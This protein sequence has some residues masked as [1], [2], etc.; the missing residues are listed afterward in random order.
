MGEQIEYDPPV[1]RKFHR[2]CSR[3]GEIR[4]HD[5]GATDGAQPAS[6]FPVQWGAALDA[7]TSASRRLKQGATATTATRQTQP[8]SASAA[9]GR[10]AGSSARREG[11]PGSPGVTL[12][13]ASPMPRRDVAGHH[14]R[15]W[16]R[17][18]LYPSFVSHRRSPAN[19]MNGSTDLSKRPTRRRGPRPHAAASSSVE[20]AANERLGWPGKRWPSVPACPPCAIEPLDPGHPNSPAALCRGLQRCWCCSSPCS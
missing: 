9:T 2:H 3:C 4:T 1:A 18:V 19:S 17:A 16:S 8:T 5:G 13:P 15:S 14:V 20:R 10:R 6:R 12:R 7:S 11:V